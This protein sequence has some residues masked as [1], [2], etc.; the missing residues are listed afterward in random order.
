MNEQALVP[1]ALREPAALAADARRVYERVHRSIAQYDA[2]SLDNFD[3]RSLLRAYRATSQKDRFL[4]ERVAPL[5]RGMRRLTECGVP[6]G[7]L[8]LRA[9]ALEREE[10]AE[11]G[12]V[13]VAMARASAALATALVGAKKERSFAAAE[14]ERA[15]TEARRRASALADRVRE[16]PM[17]EQPELR[18]GIIFIVLSAVRAG[19]ASND[20]DRAHNFTARLICFVLLLFTL[21]AVLTVL[22]ALAFIVTDREAGERLAA[23]QV[24]TT[25]TSNV[26]YIPGWL[27]DMVGIAR[28]IE[29]SV[30]PPPLVRALSTASAVAD[31]FAE[32][33]KAAAAVT[34]A[35][36][37]QTG[38]PTVVQLGVTQSLLPALYAGLASATQ[39]FNLVTAIAAIRLVYTL[40][41]GRNRRGD[42]EQRLD[43]L[44][45]QLQEMRGQT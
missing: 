25:G 44:Q 17:R 28:A 32:L 33:R 8:V 19:A 29:P 39:V 7:E 23:L 1:L 18:N 12:D 16:T 3:H 30:E 4:R 6:L 14:F 31:L 9:D 42:L 34:A 35:A 24:T 2:P 5:E 43:A 45:R 11:V 15:A 36:V 13:F 21:F 26:A 38:A 27:R 40:A 41:F 20:A 22:G 10:L 37:R